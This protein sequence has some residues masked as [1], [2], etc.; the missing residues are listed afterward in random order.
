MVGGEYCRASTLS[1][2]TTSVGFPWAGRLA[3]TLPGLCWGISGALEFDAELL[4]IPAGVFVLYALA[5]HTRWK[6]TRR[7]SSYFVDKRRQGAA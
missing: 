4:L 1:R 5:A 6:R 3:A 2:N 7:S